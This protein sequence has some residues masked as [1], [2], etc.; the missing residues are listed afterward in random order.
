MTMRLKGESEFSDEENT[1]QADSNSAEE[2]I[3]TSLGCFAFLLLTA[4]GSV[5]RVGLVLRIK[6][7]R[8]IT[9]FLNYCNR[10]IL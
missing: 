7:A 1:K 8:L 5:V 2:R 9:I 6:T 10:Q 4:C 3:V